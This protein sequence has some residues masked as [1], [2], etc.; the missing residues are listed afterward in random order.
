MTL[1]QP[2]EMDSQT[3]AAF[4]TIRAGKNVFLLL[5][6]LAILAVLASV[7]LVR[8]ANVLEPVRSAAIADAAV[9]PA[10]GK[11]EITPVATLP[12][13]ATSPTTMAAASSCK[14]SRLVDPAD[15]SKRT[16]WYQI[17]GGALWASRLLGPISC[18]LLIV[19]LFFAATQSL[20]ARG[21]GTS[22]FISAFFWALLLLA[23]LIPWQQV[24]PQSYSAGATM[25][26]SE[27]LINTRTANG[28]LC[29]PSSIFLSWYYARFLGLPIIALL[30]WIV[31]AVRTGRGFKRLINAA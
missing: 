29:A 21:G 11:K 9:Q 16:L 18:T 26:I 7:I 30:V 17:L 22:E 8:F 1:L 23:I 27:L 13:A 15:E 4:K 19:A 3:L 5:T 6:L 14:P 2:Q 20:V 24:L 10:T 28:E 25:R 31:V 12:A